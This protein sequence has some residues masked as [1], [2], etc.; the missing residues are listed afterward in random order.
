M[1]QIKSCTSAILIDDGSETIAD[2]LNEIGVSKI[3]WILH[4]HYHRDQCLG[5]L[6]FKLKGTAIAIGSEKKT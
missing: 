5:D 1:Y 2:Y 3:D 4:T 6:Q